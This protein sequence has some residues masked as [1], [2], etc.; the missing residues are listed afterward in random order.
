MPELQALKGVIKRKEF[1]IFLRFA[2]P[3]QFLFKGCPKLHCIIKTYLKTTLNY[4]S[5]HY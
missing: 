1:Q 3:L 2:F 5:L 4:K